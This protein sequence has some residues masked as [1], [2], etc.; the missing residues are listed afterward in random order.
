MH[1]YEEAF[2]LADSE[3]EKIENSDDAVRESQEKLKKA[4]LKSQN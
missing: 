2:R 3:I 1:V 4:L